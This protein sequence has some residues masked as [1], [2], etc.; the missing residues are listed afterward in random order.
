MNNPAAQSNSNINP[1]WEERLIDFTMGAMDS[2]ASAEFERGLDEC[3]AHVRLARQY[4]STV[5]MLGASVAPAEPPEGH[6]VR[7]M[8]KLAATPQEGAEGLSTAPIADGSR[9]KVLVGAPVSSHERDKDR[10]IVL[11]DAQEER[12]IDLMQAMARRQG[13]VLAPAMAIAAAL[14]LLLMGVWLWSANSSLADQENRRI[15]AER[16]LNTEQALRLEAER[17]LNDFATT[18]NVPPGYTAFQIE[19]QPGYNATATVL[20]NPNT[21]DASLLA[22]RLE[23]LPPDKVYEFWLLPTDANAPPQ[24]AGTFTSE[25]GGSARHAT[26]APSN[27]GSYA[28]FAVTLENKPGVDTPQGPMVLAGTFR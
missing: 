26:V 24:K 9:L 3:S 21:K 7:F 27:V 1:E 10:E 19:A 8:A 28:G 2:E 13:S 16:K 25:A 20:Y 23:P 18:L 15:E 14:A 11:V 6:K 4:R 22:D 5:N 12:I 17:R